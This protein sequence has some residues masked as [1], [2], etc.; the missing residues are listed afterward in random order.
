MT[1]RTIQRILKP[2]ASCAHINRPVS[3]HG[4]S[5]TFAVA[6]VH[7][8]IALPTLQRLLGHHRLTTAELYLTLFPDEVRREVRAHQRMTVSTLSR[9][10]S[11]VLT[12]A[13]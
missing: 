2:I 4:R 9:G 6:A 5:P 12:R 3:P 7:K 8:G 11:A 1:P 13:D 10:F